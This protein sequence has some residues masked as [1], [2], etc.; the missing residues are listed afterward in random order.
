[1]N[2]EWLPTNAYYHQIV[3][4]PDRATRD[5]LYRELFIQPWKLMMERVA[6][7]FNADPSDH[8]AV[9]RGWAWLLPEHLAQTPAALRKLEAAGAWEVGARA[10]AEGVARFEPYADRIPFDTVSGWLIIADPARAD[11]ANQGYTGAI[12]WNQPRLVIQFDTPDDYNLP[13]LPG[14]VVHELHHL[15]RL[16]LFPWDVVGTSVGDYI[17]HEGMAESFATAL[18]GEAV[19]GHYVTDLNGAQLE[20]ARTR[21]RDSLEI[22]GFG[23]IRSYVFGDR[24]AEQFGLP[25]VGMP[26]YGGYAVGYRVVQAYLA[27][28]G[29]SVAEATFVPADEILRISGYFD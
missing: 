9:A 21:I 15:V 13:R 4:A 20:T 23:V 18:Y 19:A 28:T 12:D 25:P 22:T 14:A 29:H 1:M 10:L 17:V 3:A 16:H 7:M 26:D 24:L 5:R 27:R 2:T 11:P 8:M 6:P